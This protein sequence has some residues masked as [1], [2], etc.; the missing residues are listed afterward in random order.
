M[1]KEI[2]HN[3]GYFISD[4]GYVFKV[5][6]G[7]EY[8]LDSYIEKGLPRVVINR[9]TYSILSLMIENFLGDISISD[10]VCYRVINKKIPLST[11][12]VKNMPKK[13]AEDD[14]LIY[15][16][17]CKQKSIQNNKRVAY[18]DLITEQDVLNCL[19]RSG[20]RCNYC[21]DIIKPNKWHLDHVYPLCEGGKN[22]P[23]NIA[24]ACETCNL[25]KNKFVLSKFIS[26]CRKISKNYEQ[27]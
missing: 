25:M 15:K 23:T 2:K 5:K 24:P 14:I 20:F 17:K 6:N 11:L 7:K 27:F 19:K 12:K 8:I 10:K 3:S 4:L 26:Q 18:L 22:R 21:N 9:K 13:M 16:Y 1:I